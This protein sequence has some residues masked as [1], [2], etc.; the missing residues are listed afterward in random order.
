MN[1]G[2]YDPDNG[3][4][5]QENLYFHLIKDL[6]ISRM[7]IL[8]VGSGRGGGLNLLYNKI[9]CLSAT[10][11]D[12][13][14]DNIDFSNKSY[15]QSIK[16]VLGDAESLDFDSSSFDIVFNIESAHCY[17]NYKKFLE[18]VVRVLKPGGLF[19][20]TDL[21]AKDSGHNKYYSNILKIRE[22][23]DI[24]EIKETD[25]T[26]QVSDSCKIDSD[27]AEHWLIKKIAKNMYE[28]YN[29]N[30]TKHISFYCRKV[31]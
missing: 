28:E 8:D 19:L 4:S 30:K 1:H 15:G 10:G 3:Y 7:H 27:F 11:V 20:S 9:G 6:D 26:Q 31:A 5:N 23:S 14:P 13:S 25:I 18:E 16:F 2:Y 21:V 12:I 22:L 29:N 17:P 24:F